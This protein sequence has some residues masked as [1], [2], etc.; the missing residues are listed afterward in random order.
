M[1]RI[2][3][4]FEIVEQ[5]TN[6]FADEDACRPESISAHFIERSSA[7]SSDQLEEYLV[8]LADTLFL[9]TGKSDNQTKCQLPI[10]LREKRM[11]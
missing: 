5:A 10:Y 4:I 11:G 6:G 7:W 8:D 3:T 9:V 1:E 2:S